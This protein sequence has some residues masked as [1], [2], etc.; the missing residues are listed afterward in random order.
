MVNNVPQIDPTRPYML[1]EVQPDGNIRMATNI[2]MDFM[3]YG[4][5]EKSKLAVQ[6]AFSPSQSGIVAAPASALGSLQ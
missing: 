4:I 5:L 2:G 1:L 3:A 6:K